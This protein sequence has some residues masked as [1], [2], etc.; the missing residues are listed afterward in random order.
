[1]ATERAAA[2][3]GLVLER[4]SHAFASVT[5]LDD[6]SLT[7]EAGEVHCLLGPSGSGKSTLLRLVAGLDLLQSG[8]IEIGGATVADSQSDEPPEKRATGFVF[9]DYALFPHLD[10]AGNIGFGMEAAGAQRSE[11]TAELLERIG[12]SDFAGAMPHTLSGGQQQRVALAR[13]L[14]RGPRIMLMDEPFSGLD[15]S[16]RDEVRGR[17][18]ELLRQ[19]GVAT[20]LVT[21][22]PE[23]AL[24]VGDRISVLV[25]GK[26]LQT[27]SP[28]D[29]YAEPLSRDVG[30]IFGPL[31]S[32][33]GHRAEGGVETACGV[34]DRAEIPDASRFEVLVRPEA[35]ELVAPEGPSRGI[36]GRVRSVV[37]AGP[38]VTVRVATE[39]GTSLLVS[40][41]TPTRWRSEDAVRVV[42]RSTAR[43]A[44]LPLSEA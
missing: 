38:T 9:Q 22:S 23:E 41:L 18:L 4:V 30:T 25:G 26:L 11:A 8:R 40:E 27:G 29:V 36:D 43:A 17:T 16:L 42:L 21:H 28:L 34:Y 44:I 39:D 35:L 12:L 6:V 14:A 19:E 13:A 37:N 15:S 24:A 33:V 5:A 31:N 7:V 3:D 2:G 32:L 1:M 20:L 10:V